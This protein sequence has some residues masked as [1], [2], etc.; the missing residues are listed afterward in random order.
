MEKLVYLEDRHLETATGRLE[1]NM[2]PIIRRRAPDFP[3]LGFTAFIVSVIAMPVIQ[4]GYNPVEERISQAVLGAHGFVQVFGI[5]ALSAGTLAVAVQLARSTTARTVWA[6]A[7]L[8]LVSSACV[9]FVAAIPTDPPGGDSVHGNA[10]LILAVGAS[11]ATIA[12]MLNASHAFR[13]EDCVREL[14][15]PSL[16]FGV[17]SAA[18]LTMMALNIGPAGL[19]QRIAVVCQI[20]W[21]ALLAWNLRCQRDSRSPQRG[22]RASAHP[23]GVI[24]QLG[25]PSRAPASCAA[26]F[27][28]SELPWDAG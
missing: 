23:G 5:F 18:L 1:S 13:R 19:V 22:P 2:A 14:A 28:R 27:S 24:A 10:H 8:M 21:L 12:A 3:F 25:A 17:A 9:A 26:P 6:T 15:I 16:F 7:G 4:D 11:I 20:G